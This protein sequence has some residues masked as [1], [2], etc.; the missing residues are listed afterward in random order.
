[1]IQITWKEYLTDFIRAYRNLVDGLPTRM[2]EKV[3]HPYNRRFLKPCQI[4]VMRFGTTLTLVLTSTNN[5]N[6]SDM[7]II[8]HEQ[9]ENSSEFMDDF[10]KRNPELKENREEIY[11]LLF[12]KSHDPYTRYALFTPHFSEISIIT[13]EMVPPDL[14][15]IE[16]FNSLVESIV[17]EYDEEQRKVIKDASQKLKR[18]IEAIPESETRARLEE[19]VKSIESALMNIG[20]FDKISKK[21]ASLEGDISGLRT[22]VGTSEYFKDWK[23]L[24]SDVQRLKVEHVPREVIDARVNELNTRIDSF[25]E[26]KAAYDKILAQQTEFMKQQADV[27]KQ[28]SSFIKWIKYATI[29]LPIAVISVPIV[30][31]V[32]I[33]IRRLLNIP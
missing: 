23:L 14:F 3:E 5:E 33:V 13:P 12:D 9:P 10:V 20:S 29:L 11:K 24:V 28:Q 32:S 27:M 17:D 16:Q 15:A 30:E 21:V 22:L 19:R 1:V 25:S 31:L 2:R 7:E 26:I 8:V 4:E 6:R 18:D